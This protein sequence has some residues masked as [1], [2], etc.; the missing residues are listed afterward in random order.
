MRLPDFRGDRSVDPASAAPL[1]AGLNRIGSGVFALVLLLGGS[2]AWIALEFG[3]NVARLN[4]VN[5]L[6]QTWDGALELLAGHP[7]DLTLGGNDALLE[8]FGTLGADLSA[9]QALDPRNPDLD[10]AQEALGLASARA[11]EA[12]TARAAAAARIEALQG[13]VARLSRL[14]ADWTRFADDEEVDAAA[15]ARRAEAEQRRL[16]ALLERLSSATLSAT[17][18][19]REMEAV[20]RFN[21]AKVGAPLP[22]GEAVLGAE[23][24][25]QICTPEEHDGPDRLCSPHS[26]RVRDALAALRDAPAAKRARRTVAAREALG[27]YVRAGEVLFT[28]VSVR[29]AAAVEAGRTARERFE[30]TSATQGALARLN[31]ALGDA[32]ET[33]RHVAPR[34]REEIEALDRRVAGL[35]GQIEL[36][37]DAVAAGLAQRGFAASP[38]ATDTLRRDWR[39]TVELLTARVRALTACDV[40]TDALDALIAR[41]G[42]QTRAASEFWVSTISR[43]GLAALVLLG[44]LSTGMVWGGKRLIALPMTRTVGAILSLARGDH[45][46]PV[47]LRSRA[48]GFGVLER[49]LER[50]RLANLE[51]E[52]LVRQTEAQRQEIQHQAL[53][54]ALTGLPNRRS[55]DA[56]IG[57]LSGEAG[58]ENFTLLHI[59]VDRFKEIN[60]TLGH[61]AGDAVLRE[62]A[63]ILTGMLGLSDRAFRIGG[64]EFLIHREGDVPE[65]DTSRLA[66]AIIEA[67]NRPIDYQGHACRIGASIG[68]AHGRD[69]KG[70][71]SATL[72]NAD[73]ALYEAKSNGKNRYVYF[74][75]R[76]Q[77]QTINRKKLSDQLHEALEREEFIPYYQPQYFSE[78]GALRGIET[79]CRWN[80]PE[81]G[82]LSPDDFMAQAEAS[83]LVGRID[84]ILQRKAAE[85]LAM[86]RARGHVIPKISFNVS[87]DRLM[88]ADFAEGLIAAAGHGTTVAVELLESMSLDS[89]SESVR[90]ALDALKERRIGIEI[91][92]FGS[93][94]ASIAGLIAIG[95]DAMK[96]DGVIVAPITVSEQHLRLVRAIIDIGRTLGIEVIAERVETEEHARILREAGCAVLQGYA[97]AQPMSAAALAVFLDVAAQGGVSARTG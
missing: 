87:T 64:D 6:H 88:H 21:A 47:Q 79:L 55:A 77:E 1:A 66:G 65:E 10:A 42:A 85:D 34:S 18:I 14:G 4:G 61:D 19:E 39:E 73:I 82:L 49:A 35:I 56:L 25:P 24:I 7:Q 51:R 83:M 31:H 58:A 68:I 43:I 63:A 75:A 38:A 78:T 32:A 72:M 74:A 57:R 81:L 22:F 36:R 15:E 16:S 41:I 27:A 70:E 95:P 5:A 92:D 8:V 96:I 17:R 76:L 45:I 44:V 84:R 48:F 69:A 89:I 37:L 28:E 13:A 80:H 90:F 50:L 86:L 93:C 59:D 23:G 12:E 46:G 2:I 67:M 33:L 26:G 20:A 9:A 62:V 60:D 91:D 52:A 53:H 71:G 40:A 11:R 97:L 29:L 54:D 94:R 30:T 3:A